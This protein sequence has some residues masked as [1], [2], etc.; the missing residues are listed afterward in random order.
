MKYFLSKILILAL[1]FLILSCKNSQS[2]F[3][4]EPPIIPLVEKTE[5]PMITD[6]SG[7]LMDSG[8]RLGEGRSWDLALG[9]LDGDGDLDALVA[10]G[11]HGNTGSQVWLN[12][13][14]G[15]F[16]KYG[17]ELSAGMGLDL[18]DL[19]QDGDLDVIIVSWDAVGRI[20]LND[21]MGRF[22]DSYQI[23]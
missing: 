9:D 15:L 11:P 6:P 16:S 13:G 23:L 10:N 18:G 17:E 2:V 12:D 20:W 8:Q 21:G 19:D 3:L 4:E 1:S 5:P 14:L 22:S 7:I